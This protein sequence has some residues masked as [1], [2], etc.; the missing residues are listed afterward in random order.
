[1]SLNERE[2]HFVFLNAMLWS[3]L[4]CLSLQTALSYSYIYIRIWQLSI[5]DVDCWLDC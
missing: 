4:I 3:H 5:S 1:M 2:G